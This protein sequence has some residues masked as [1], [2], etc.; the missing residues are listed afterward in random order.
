MFVFFFVGQ[1][2]RKLFIHI[3]FINENNEVKIVYKSSSKHGELNKREYILNQKWF[4][5]KCINTDALKSF[6]HPLSFNIEAKY[7]FGHA[8]TVLYRAVNEF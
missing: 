3:P 4:G 1:N 5:L 8:G 2:N 6:E 7:D